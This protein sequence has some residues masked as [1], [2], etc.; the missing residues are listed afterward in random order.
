MYAINQFKQ[1]IASAGLTPPDTIHADG[2]LHRYSTDNKPSHRN[3]W[4]FMH[5]DGVLWGQAGSWDING[6]D[7]ICH[8]YAN[9][10]S[11]MTQAERDIQRAQQKAAQE[12]REVELIRRHQMASTDAAQRWQAATACI[13]HN[14]LTTKGVHGYGVRMDGS[15]A[16]IVP[17]WDAAG[18]LCSLQT[19]TAG[20]EKRFLSG[21]KV[22][23][24]YHS[25]GKPA[26]VL[27]VCEGYAT[28][29]SIHECTGHAVA[30]AFNAGNLE[31]V[32]V[33]L[34]TKYPA[35][36]IIIAADDDHQTPGNPGMTKATAAAQAAGATLAVPIFKAATA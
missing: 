1:A 3:G 4:Y 24:C 16:L 13:Q 14:Y 22:K 6:G 21:G 9:S 10:E 26:G 20:G 29:A 31:P 8:W 35:L 23:G 33:A 36:K 5:Q 28:G 25:I 18:E 19:I 12:Q 15:G 27:I 7:P 2:E 17:M 11:A 32:A 34:R 30:V